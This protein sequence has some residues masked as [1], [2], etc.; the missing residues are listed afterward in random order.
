MSMSSGCGRPQS[1]VHYSKPGFEPGWGIDYPKGWELREMTGASGSFNVLFF[2]PGQE[3]GFTSNIGVTVKRYV[4]ASAPEDPAV[5]LLTSKLR[6]KEARLLDK[7]KTK[8]GGANATEVLVS[9]K[10]QDK[11]LRADAQW[12][13]VKERF[14]V[15]QKGSFLWIVRYQAREGDFSLFEKAFSHSLRTLTCPGCDK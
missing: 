10:I 1:F 4:A 7:R 5:G 11:I 12:I 2:Q 13:S 15:F 6:F 3:K 9:Y 8:V 14:V